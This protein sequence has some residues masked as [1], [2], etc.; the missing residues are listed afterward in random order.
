MSENNHLHTREGGAIVPLAQAC[1]TG[2]FVAILAAIPM[3][4]AGWRIEDV[5]T[6]VIIAFVVP[7]LTVWLGLLYHWFK[8]TVIEQYTQLDIDG[9]GVI[10][11][12]QIIPVRLDITE[13]TQ[14]GYTQ[15]TRASFV[16][17]RKLAAIARAVVSGSPFSQREI[18]EKLKICS[19]GEYE[20][21]RDEMIDRGIVVLKNPERTGL[22][23]EFSRA[24][25]AAM[26][27]M[28]DTPLP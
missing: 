27:D 11:K 28:A 3:I 14:G 21:I 6:G 8:L 10:G 1:A 15:V 18:V 7:A 22:G 16:D 20:E 13:I 9:D 24:G 23:T 12:E 2:S 26:R 25:M 19:R 17:G 4:R 5:F